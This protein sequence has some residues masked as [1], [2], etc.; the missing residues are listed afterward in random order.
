MLLEYGT[1]VVQTELVISTF[2]KPEYLR[3]CLHSVVKQTYVPDSICIADDGSGALTKRIIDTFQLSHPELSV[4]HVWHEN[5][6]FRKTK[7]LNKAVITSNA[8]YMIFTDDDC[9]MHPTFI[10]RHINLAAAGKFITGSVIRLEQGFTNR[11]LKLG[12]FQ[13]DHKGRPLEWKPRS[14]SEFLKSMPFHP[15]IMAAF[16]ILS[17]VKCSWA[18]GNSSTYRDYILTVNGFDE[19]MQYGAEDKEFGA[20]LINSGLRGRHLRYT[21]PLYHLEHSR[22]YVND[23][24]VQKNRITLNAVRSS[25]KT[26]S[27]NGI[28]R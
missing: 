4:R 24:Q 20:R 14:V 5:L 6:G 26:S 10:E 12:E 16:D 22:A 9:V 19:K 8:D 1:G 23:E 18:G 13:W 11:V 15:Y 28:Y 17:P 21:A 2:Q 3:L 7:I 27:E 25:G